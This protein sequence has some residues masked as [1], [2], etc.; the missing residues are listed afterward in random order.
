MKNKVFI[1][2]ILAI[3]MMLTCFV[4]CV[5][6]EDNSSVDAPLQEGVIT[7]EDAVCE[8][9]K[10]IKDSGTVATATASN[11]AAISYSMTEEEVGKLNNAFKSKLQV[12]SEGAIV[13]QYDDVKKF[14]VDITAS[15]E[16]CEPVTAEMTISVINPYLNYA[17]RQLADAKVDVP[18][19]SSVAYV[20]D[21][22]VQ[23]TY[24]LASKQKLP[25]GLTMSS[26]GT[27]TGTPTQVGPGAPFI[28]KAKAKGFSD[29]EREFTID[30]V[31]DHKSETVSKIVN[32][33]DAN[34]VKELA[35]AY[36]GSQYVNQAGVAGTASAL[37]GNNITYTLAEGTTLPEGIALYPNGAII[38]KADVRTECEFSV[39]AS[40]TGC[41][42]LT[43]SFKLAVKPM[44][45]R[46]E[47]LRG[48]L[49][50][51]E[52]ANY[53]IAKADAGE[54]VQ[55]TYTMTKE[56]ADKLSA[57]YGLA[58]TPEGI[59]TGTPTKVTKL[60]FFKVTAEAE[61]FTPTTVE[62]SFRINEPLQ[63]PANGKFEAEYID[64][65]GKNG[66]G[67]SASPSG[68]DMIDGALAE[69]TSNGYFV[70]YMF[71]DT[72][73]L[74][75]V[76]YA[77]AD[78]T[79]AKLYLALGSEIGTVTFTPSDF[80]VYTYV[81]QTPTGTKTT[82]NYGSMRVSG[83]N[84]YTSFDE[85]QAGTVS[86]KQGW[87]VIQLAVHTNTLRGGMIGGPGVD[88]IRVDTSVALKWI[89]CSYNVV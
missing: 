20:L 11:G 28:V 48:E 12:T 80:G 57:E 63:A 2:V 68:T 60:M 67:Y 69:M 56:D 13:G 25:E 5:P 47:A 6:T 55:I 74:E 8:V 65:T 83:G 89:P 85:Y 35:T 53:N 82:V 73:T 66:T 42:P 77:E 27:I 34:G 36:V 81:G 75:F 86:L 22:D 3:V 64:L 59:V 15:A 78:V 45:I 49:T 41:E 51:G 23:V 9:I 32:F 38:G 79:N 7:Y 10:G 40:A 58:V 16:K 84:Q 54:G 26:D 30:V 87:N 72:I 18:Y 71:N 62:I 76:I 29:T 50:K 33:G 17:G 61:G 52:A 19:A 14:K 39:T 37:N 44:R 31:L 46:F 21:E 4:S 70:N 43:R 88:Y 24:S 1:S